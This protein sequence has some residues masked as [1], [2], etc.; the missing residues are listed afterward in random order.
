MVLGNSIGRDASFPRARVINLGK[1][2]KEKA[3]QDWP[4][5]R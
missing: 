2:E 4:Y 5:N 1:I 3:W